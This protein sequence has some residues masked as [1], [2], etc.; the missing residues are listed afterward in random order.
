MKIY[1]LIIAYNEEKEEIEYI[2]EQLEG[3]SESVLE[4]L[5]VIN[6]GENFDEDDLKIIADSYIIGEA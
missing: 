5:G 4:G 6:V 2:T 1:T 3:S